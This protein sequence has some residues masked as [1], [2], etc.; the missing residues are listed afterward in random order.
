MIVS[1]GLWRYE[2]RKEKSRQSSECSFDDSLFLLF[3]NSF[4][5]EPFRC[6][7]LS[8]SNPASSSLSLLPALSTLFND[9]FAFSII[10][11]IFSFD[12]DCF[13]VSNLC[14]LIISFSFWTRRIAWTVASDSSW[15]MLNRSFACNLGHL[16]LLWLDRLSS[17]WSML[18]SSR[19]L[20]FQPILFWV[21]CAI[22]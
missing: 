10:S 4:V 19:V 14:R 15:R 20:V 1:R 13:I 22:T 6:L 18:N 5:N 9:I 17:N 8:R 2:A 11:S 7:F 3:P 16:A 12:F 21:Q